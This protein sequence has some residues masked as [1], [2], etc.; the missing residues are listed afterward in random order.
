MTVLNLLVGQHGLVNRAPPLVAF[1]LVGEAGFVEL[2]EA[3]LGPAVVFGVGSVDFAAP[4]NGVTELLGLFTE[5]FNVGGGSG[6]R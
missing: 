2:E 1:L 4:V 6:L 3:P 5:V